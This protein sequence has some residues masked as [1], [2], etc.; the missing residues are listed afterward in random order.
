[1]AEEKKSEIGICYECSTKNQD[2]SK[3]EVFHCDKCRKWFCKQ[4]LEA[5]FPYF[6]D[7]ETQFD[8]QGNPAVKSMFYSEYRRKE[9]HADFEYLRTKIIEMELEEQYRDW[10]IQKAID[11]MVEANRAR[12]EKA[13]SIAITSVRSGLIEQDNPLK[14]TTKTYENKFGHTFSVPKEVYADKIF[15]ER[16]NNANLL[17]EV[18][19]IV[20]QYYKKNMAKKEIQKQKKKHWWQR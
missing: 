10:L 14:R 11:N 19:E 20:T 13:A 1:M 17:C 12:N 8:V 15:R 2:S 9:G 5:K 16:L 18:E 4:H 3:K 7:W 6:V